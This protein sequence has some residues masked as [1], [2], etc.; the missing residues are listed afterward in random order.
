MGCPN[1][2]INIAT[3]TF[4]CSVC[5]L[6]AG[7]DSLSTSRVTLVP[8]SLTLLDALHEVPTLPELLN[9]DDQKALSDASRSFHERFVAQ[10]QAVTVTC[11]ED[12]AL[13]SNVAGGLC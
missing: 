11:T 13:V 7:T 4:V 6:F 10:V 9:T 8:A 5:V 12:L 2:W 1:S 3:L